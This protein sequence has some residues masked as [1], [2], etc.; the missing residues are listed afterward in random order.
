MP[1]NWYLID[2]LK[3]YQS[4]FKDFSKYLLQCVQKLSFIFK[5]FVSFY[6]Y[7]RQ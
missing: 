6:C 3:D 7:Q 4:V 5:H 2:K 1:T